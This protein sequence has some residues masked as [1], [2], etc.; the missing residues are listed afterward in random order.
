ME[1]EK[2]TE[3]SRLQPDVLG[4]EMQA[5]AGKAPLVM[6]ELM[7]QFIERKSLVSRATVRLRMKA[8]LDLFSADTG[9]PP[10]PALSGQPAQVP[11][12][13]LAQG[14]AAYA[15]PQPIGRRVAGEA[16]QMQQEVERALQEEDAAGAPADVAPAPGAEVAAAAPI[17]E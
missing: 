9:Y 11:P 17:P 7:Q 6:G 5:L 14:Y 10:I 3:P 15:P 2:K 8:L 16:D 13:Y 1:P 12:R 4:P